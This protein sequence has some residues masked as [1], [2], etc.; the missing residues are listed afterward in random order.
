MN[1]PQFKPVA[2]HA[3]LVDFASEISD[4]V[5]RMV[6]A[7]DHAITTAQIKGLQEVVPA[8]VNL[9]VVFDPLETDH[10]QVEK[11]VRSLLPVA[12]ASDAQAT[13]HTLD[14]CYEA[15]FSPDLA[16]VAKACGMSEDAVIQAHSSARY[17]V[18]MYGFAP[19]YAYLAG[20]PEAIQVPRKTAPVRD[21]PAGSVMIAGPQCLA[22]TI[23]MPT[24]WSI[25]GHTPA[26]IMTGNPDRP[27]LFDVGDTVSFNRVRREAL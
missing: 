19:G 22:T 27:F 3:I 16:A 25:I 4:D 24:G 17:R 26:K 21:I 15:D 18:G 7:L 9:L 8:L 23:V 6:I 12:P 5:N 10:V 14:I 20:V 13:H 2:D 11:D 1:A